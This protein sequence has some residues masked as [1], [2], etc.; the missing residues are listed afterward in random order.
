MNS[1]CM[2]VTH[3]YCRI[4]SKTST[5]KMKLFGLVLVHLLSVCLAQHS[6]EYD[7][8]S[9]LADEELP[10]FISAAEEFSVEVGGEITFPCQVQHLGRKKLVFRFNSF[11][12]PS[13]ERLYFA[14]PNV[15]SENRRLTRE[16]DNSFRL[17]N[18]RR[19][20][21]GQYACKLYDPPLQVVHKLR[22]QYPAKIRRISPDRQ[23][24]VKGDTVTLQCEAEGNPIPAISWSKQGG[25]LPSGS[26]SEEGFS[27]TMEEVNRHEAGKYVCTASNGIGEPSSAMMSIEV[28]FKPEIVTEETILHTGD[29]DEAKLVCIVHGHP[30][31]DVRWKRGDHLVAS[32][33]HLMTH[34]GEHRHSLIIRHVAE[35]DFGEYTCS[36][37]NRH[38]ITESTLTLTGLPM[39][40]R[41]TSSPAGGEKASYTLTWETESFSPIVQYRIK[42]R[43]HQKQRTNQQ[44]FG[45]WQDSLYSPHVQPRKHNRLRSSDRLKVMAHA[46]R[47]LEPASDYQA[48]VAVENKFGWSKGSDVFTF[49][50]RKEVARSHS[51]SA[52]TTEVCSALVLVF[53]LILHFTV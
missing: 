9:E 22:V 25:R 52:G 30:T 16:D 50:T 32:D 20:D 37:G 43:K 3:L 7:Y 10:Q 11:D 13:K 51:A 53:S 6:L 47:N 8:Q 27:I 46:I 33:K 40:P 5:M 34:D 42:Y 36:A 18:I 21:A 1:T 49:N 19:S 24:V 14:G 45:T 48:I 38:G 17:S 23:H 29:G 28:E 4:N 39:I 12:T 26:R 15:I 31:P 44:M 2:L 41:L 35:E